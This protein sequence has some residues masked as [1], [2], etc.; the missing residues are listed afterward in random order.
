LII[1][2]QLIFLVRFLIYC[3]SIICEI[4]ID[5][6]LKIHYNEITY[7]SILK[8]NKIMDKSNFQNNAVKPLLERSKTSNRR[9]L[10]FKL[11]T[12]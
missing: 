3:K 1:F 4:G 11:D 7:K 10:A 12:S 8:S 2:N 6:G 9:K 5:F